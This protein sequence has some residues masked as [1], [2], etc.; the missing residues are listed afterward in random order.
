MGSK[1]GRKFRKDWTSEELDEI[2]GSL[3]SAITIPV[4]VKV[5]S[6][7]KVLNMEMIEPI[8]RGARKIAVQD[9]GCR[10]DMKNCDAPPVGCIN[11]DE[12]A[13]ATLDYGQYNI[14]EATIDEA[15]D[16]L[17]QSNE[18]GLVHMAYTF[19]EKPDKV[20]KICSCCSCC[21]HT[22]SGLIRFGTA[23]HVQPSGLI[24]AQDSS[25]CTNCGACV[26]R[27]QFD[28]RNME[29][30]KMEY[31]P[32]SCFGCGLCVDTC[33]AG[34]ITLRQRYMASPL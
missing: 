14:H 31:S 21:C 20:T 18:A 15:L 10:V 27:C 28:A 16:V 32:G 5:D 13:D 34:A 11:L 3:G 24:A 25:A 8:L 2:Y 6:T 26:T 22:L 23:K 12:V 19:R 1:M 29:D 9:C 30:G 7:L 17:R 4:N 33:K